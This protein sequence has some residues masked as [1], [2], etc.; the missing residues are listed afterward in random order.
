MLDTTRIHT[1]GELVAGRVEGREYQTCNQHK[2]SGSRGQ[3]L[4]PG[5]QLEPFQIVA[6]HAS[7]LQFKKRGYMLKFTCWENVNPT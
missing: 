5:W 2:V 3:G 1:D 6:W 7:C 4:T